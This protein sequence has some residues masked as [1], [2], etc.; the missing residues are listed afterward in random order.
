MISESLIERCV[1]SFIGADLKTIA[2]SVKALSDSFTKKRGDLPRNYLNDADRRRAYIAGFILPN[3]AKVLHCLEEASQSGAIPSKGKISMLDL[4]C[5]P[6][7]AS[8]ATSAFFGPSRKLSVTAIEQ[9]KHILQDGKKLFDSLDMPGRSFEA[10]VERITPAKI[11]RQ[12]AGRRFDIIVVANL[13]NELGDD[14]VAFKLIRNLITNHLNKDGVIIVIDPALKKTT[15]P[16]MAMRDRLLDEDEKVDV[17]AP[18]LHR[19]SCPMRKQNERDWCHFYLE[20]KRPELIKQLDELTGLDRRHLKMAYFIFVSALRSLASDLNRWRVV[21]SPLI[22]K[23]K[24]ELILCSG[25]G[26]LKRIMRVDRDA[27]EVNSHFKSAMRGDI[28]E[29]NSTKRIRAKDS[30]RIIH[31]YNDNN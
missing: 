17:I 27:S 19:Q 18:C 10:I 30:F 25:G 23:G 8:L 6:A 4:G 28:V 22:S 29:T 13:L 16:L 2:P 3:A 31:V 7:T 9:S 5:G 15:I 24:R 11:D 20:W 12:L 1:H 21:S 14:E 26:E